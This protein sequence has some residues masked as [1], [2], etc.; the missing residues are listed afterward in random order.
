[1]QRSDQ[2]KTGADVNNLRADCN[3]D[4]LAFYVNGFKLAEVQDSTLTHGDLGLLA[5][6][7]DQPG[8]DIVFD[9]FVVL[10]P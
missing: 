10:K 6:T 7:F 1:M 9:N 8:V 5:G 2:I 3:G 4:T